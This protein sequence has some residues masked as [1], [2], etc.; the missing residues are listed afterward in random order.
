MRIAVEKWTYVEKFPQFFEQGL[1]AY[2]YSVD[3]HIRSLTSEQAVV[4]LDGV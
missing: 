2:S 3:H 1:A 4:I